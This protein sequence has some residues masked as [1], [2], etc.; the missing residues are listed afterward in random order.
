MSRPSPP[1]SPAIPKRRPGRAARAIAVVASLAVFAGLAAWWTTRDTPQR[2]WQRASDA[3]NDR[4]PAEAEALLNR[5]D[6]LRPP[7]PEQKFLRAQIVGVQGREDEAASLFRGIPEGDVPPGA[8]LRLIPALAD[9]E[10]IPDEGRNLVVVATVGRILHFRIFDA[11]GQRIANTDETRL[12]A[13]AAAIETLRSELAR[14]WPPAIPSA[15]E[16]DR[17]IAQVTAIARPVP[18]AP[19]ARLRAGQLERGRHRVRAAEADFLDALKLDPTLAQARRE[20]IYIYG[21]QLRREAMREQFYKLA[22]L[23]PPTFHDA[24][25]LGLSRNVNWEAAEAAGILAEYVQADPDDRVSRLALA[26]HLQTL[27]R[28]EEVETT[29]APLAENDPAV[30]EIRAQTALAQGDLR[31]ATD[32]AAK[33]TVD[34]PELAF[35]RARLAAARRDWPTAIGYYRAMLADDPHSRE[36]LRG[37]AQALTAKGNAAEAKPYRD[38]AQAADRLGHLVDQAGVSGASRNLELIHQLGAACLDAG[39]FPEARI[40]YRLAIQND[41]LD[42]RAQQGLFAANAGLARSASPS[43]P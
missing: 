22:E 4:H 30:L 28:F 29:L 10:P 26:R 42:T 20:L 37:I 24:L 5:L 33:G 41:P 9:A 40:W 18:V 34:A 3:F 27:N 35:V 25:L 13:R 23:V 7:G 32:F 1:T 2:L 17:I 8:E 19:L 11:D 31:A 36:G 21:M 12:P 15:A 43:K 6:R 14:L 39:L 38:A 16:H